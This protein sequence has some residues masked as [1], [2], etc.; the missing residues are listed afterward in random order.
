MIIVIKSVVNKN[1]NKDYYNII[2]EKGS[3]KVNPIHDI[4][5]WTFVYF[6]CYISIWLTFFNDVNNV[7]FVTDGIS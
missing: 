6:K 4:L 5:K 2:L 1:K 3:Y 7:T